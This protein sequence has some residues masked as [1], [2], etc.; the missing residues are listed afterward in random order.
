MNCGR[1]QFSLWQ[2]YKRHALWEV[3]NEGRKDLDEVEGETLVEVCLI[4]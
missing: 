1:T 4:P 3:F 2:F